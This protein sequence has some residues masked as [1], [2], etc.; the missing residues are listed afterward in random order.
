MTKSTL[1]QYIALTRWTTQQTDSAQ[2][3]VREF[4]VPVLVDEQVIWL[5]VTISV[6]EGKSVFVDPAFC[7][8]RLTG[9]PHPV[10]ASTPGR[11]RPLRCSS[12]STPLATNPNS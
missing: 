9:E 5:Q 6:G 7:E 2:T 8:S 12:W 11:V 10:G 3:K 4:K 1:G